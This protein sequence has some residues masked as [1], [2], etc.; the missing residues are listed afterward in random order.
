MLDPSERIEAVTP[1]PDL[2][3]F[4]T[5]SLRLSVAP[6]VIVVVIEPS[7]TW[8]GW[9]STVWVV[10]AASRCR[11]WAVVEL[12]SVTE[13][14]AAAVGQVLD[15]DAV[16]VGVHLG[17]DVA[18]SA[19]LMAST[20]SSTV[21]M[22]AF[23]RSSVSLVPP[24]SVMMSVPWATPAPPLSAARLVLPEMA[25]RC[26]SPPW[27]TPV[28]LA[29]AMPS[30]VAVVVPSWR[31]GGGEAALRA[32]AGVGQL[33]A[34][35]GG[36]DR[37]HDADLGGGAGGGRVDRVDDVLERFGA[38]QIDGDAV[39]RPVGQLQVAERARVP[40]R[41]RGRRGARSSVRRGSGCR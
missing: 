26:R 17:V 21:W 28:P 25:A 6:T 37:G 23:R 14:V 8:V 18:R 2:L 24:E 4:V 12:P 31:I 19:R 10:A 29:P 27:M 39:A 11:S 32:A 34:V 20:T 38:G 5:R 36:V 3:M 40:A 15:L 9:L 33:D 22:F 35:A 13:R 41:R 7:M 1:A 30:R 16:A